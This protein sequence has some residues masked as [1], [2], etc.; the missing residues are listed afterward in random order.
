MYYFGWSLTNHWQR[1]LF[2]I[3]H[4]C[5]GLNSQPAHGYPLRVKISSLM[6]YWEM[7]KL[8]NYHKIRYFITPDRR[9]SRRLWKIDESGSQIARIYHLS[10]V[11][12]TNCNPKNLFLMVFDLR[13]SIVSTF[14]IVTYPVCVLIQWIRETRARSYLHFSVMIL[15][16]KKFVSTPD[17][18]QSKTL[19]AIDERGSKLARN[20]VFVCLLLY[21][22]STIFQLN[23]DRSSCVEP[24]LS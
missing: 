23:R 9:Q 11:R 24:V 21:V 6:L 17:S 2:P 12:Q 7:T 14:S 1:A 3:K 20:S 19:L 22:P 18:E 5:R 15:L 16:K 13:S 10:P 4:D 8:F